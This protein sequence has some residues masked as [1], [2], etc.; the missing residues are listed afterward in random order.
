MGKK[1]NK[2]GVVPPQVKRVRAARRAVQID[3]QTPKEFSHV[4]ETHKKDYAAKARNTI[5]IENCCM[6]GYYIEDCICYDE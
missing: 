2:Q 6:C 4:F 1:K 3:L 5:K